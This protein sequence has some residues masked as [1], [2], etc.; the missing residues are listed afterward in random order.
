M[1]G[2]CRQFLELR[3]KKTEPWWL[4]KPCSVNKHASFFTGTTN[5]KILQC[6][7]NVN[8]PDVWSS[9]H[10]SS[11]QVE[12]L[13]HAASHCGTKVAREG[14]KQEN[15]R[16]NV[17]HLIYFKCSCLESYLLTLVPC[18]GASWSLFRDPLL[19]C[20]RLAAFWRFWQPFTPMGN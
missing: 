8:L 5:H 13:C 1:P 12:V 4:W 9:I 20:D 3:Q 16:Q 17:V 11:Q 2:G 6:N 15:V 14:Q 19:V 7:G 18:W 10:S